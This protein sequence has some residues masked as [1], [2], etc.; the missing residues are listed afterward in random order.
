MAYYENKILFLKYKTCR[1]RM[2]QK[3]GKLNQIFFISRRI[4]SKN[5]LTGLP[6]SFRV[7]GL[8]P[9]GDGVY[10]VCGKM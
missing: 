1:E 6:G 7:R 2:Q 5:P 9:A 3:M 4:I 8:I 10:F